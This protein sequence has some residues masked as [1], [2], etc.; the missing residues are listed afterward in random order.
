MTQP[1]KKL[2]ASQLVYRVTKRLFPDLGCSDGS[3][4]FGSPGGMHT[5]GG[6]D[7][8]RDRDVNMLRRRLMAMSQI[9]KTIAA[10]S[11]EP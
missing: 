4:V 3:C 10:T 7:C 8:I 9:A 6:C 11:E 2:T 1:G 5:N